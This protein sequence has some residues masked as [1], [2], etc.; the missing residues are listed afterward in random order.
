MRDGEFE[1]PYG[2]FIAATWAMTASRYMADYDVTETDMAMVAVALRDRAIDNPRAQMRKPMS[3]E[4]VLNSP[5][6][7]SP[8]RRYNCAIVS[9][10]ACAVVVESV[11]KARS[12]RN[13]APIL[14]GEIAYGMPGGQVTDDMGQV[15]N[16]YSARIG[17]RASS[18]RALDAAHV[19]LDDIDLLFTYDPF[20]HVPMLFFEGLGYCGDGEGG[21]LVREGFLDR[22]VGA[23]FNLHGGLHSYCHPGN[24]GGLFMTI[25]AYRQLVGE[26]LGR[27]AESAN[28]ALIHGYGANKGVFATTILAKETP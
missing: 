4:D 16:P 17:T 23:T 15:G 21:Q 7:S 18:Q 28:M 25:E 1:S 2:T 9:D 12:R 5:V 13:H 6:V 19:T 3:I 14:S 11:E 26:Q 27:K 20:S 22:G 10:G 8:L 24:A